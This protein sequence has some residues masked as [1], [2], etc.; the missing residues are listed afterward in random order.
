M[1]ARLLLPEP[2]GTDYL[3]NRGM[4]LDLGFKKISAGI[5]YCPVSLP[6]IKIWE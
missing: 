2:Q 6:K 1:G 4:T 3:L 5:A